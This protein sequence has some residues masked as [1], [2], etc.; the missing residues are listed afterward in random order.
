MTIFTDLIL[1]WLLHFQLDIN[2]PD[3][4]QELQSSGISSIDVKGALHTVPKDWGGPVPPHI[5][6]TLEKS[7]SLSGEGAKRGH[8]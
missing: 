4:L 5:A 1:N 3:F 7:G 8:K 2:Q 6:T